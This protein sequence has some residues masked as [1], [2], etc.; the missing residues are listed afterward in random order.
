[1]KDPSDPTTLSSN[2]VLDIYQG[3]D[4]TLWIGTTGGLNKYVPASRTF[5]AYREKNGLPNDY[6]YGILEDAE[7]YLWLSTNKGLARFDPRKMTFKNY[8]RSD[9]L[10]GSE[11]NQWAYFKNKEGVMFFGG[12]NGIN[13]F[14]SRAH[15]GQS[16]RSPGRAHRL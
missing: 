8:D 12:V 9:G 7:G 14:S 13:A 6:V 11:F 16:F 15:R 3:R 4:D 1:M 10:Q 5:I 2:V